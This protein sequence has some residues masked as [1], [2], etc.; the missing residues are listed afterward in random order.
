MAAATIQP[1]TSGLSQTF[2]WRI[3]LGAQAY[4]LRKWP[5][6]H[7]GPDRLRWMQQVL[8]LARA[9]DCPFVPEL[10][11][12][13]NGAPFLVSN[14]GLWELQTWRPGEPDGTPPSLARVRAAFQA[15]AQFHLATRSL[16]GETRP[17]HA[18]LERRDRLRQLLAGEAAAVFA[19]A[20]ESIDSPLIAGLAH[21]AQVVF[22]AHG[23][24]WLNQSEALSQISVGLLPAIRDVR[25]E[26]LLFVGNEV[27]GLVDFGAM[28]LDTRLVDLAR[29][30]GSY[31]GEMPE[32]RR[33][34]L[35]AYATIAPLAVEDVTRIDLI[36]RTG[37]LI[38]AFNWM[39]WLLLEEQ[40][41]AQS[42]EAVA[43]MAE[44]SYR[45][46]Q[47]SESPL[48]NG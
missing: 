15:L 19:R 32:L 16:K 33:E 18:V 26:H 34:A 29:L 1:I 30:L 39:K 42:R 41:F 8:A 21:A 35:Q 3:T 14:A 31:C 6:K 48:F 4:C 10:V 17:A 43:R 38:S 20:A 27:A 13:S 12:L 45:L 28:R 24:T 25:R 2:V 40:A 11:H 7:P 37:E 9:N 36:D 22:I 5:L 46:T 47:F 44:I 23:Q